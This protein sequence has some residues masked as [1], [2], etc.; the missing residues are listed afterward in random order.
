MENKPLNFE[1]FQQRRWCPNFQKRWR[2]F[3]FLK[4]DPPRARQNEESRLQVHAQPTPQPAVFFHH[5]LPKCP[6]FFFDRRS[7]VQFTDTWRLSQRA[8]ADDNNERRRGA[9]KCGRKRRW[10]NKQREGRSPANHYKG[11]RIRI[12]LFPWKWESGWTK[13]KGCC[14]FVNVE[15]SSTHCLWKGW[16]Q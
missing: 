12:L 10:A 2:P 6:K 7:Q 13:T 9:G 15:Q 3:L 16:F 1:L 8:S 5:R 14:L 11:A 4:V